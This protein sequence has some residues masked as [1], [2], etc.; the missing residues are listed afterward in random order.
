MRTRRTNG[1]AVGRVNTHTVIHRYRRTHFRVVGNDIFNQGIIIKAEQQGIANA[2]AGAIHA[3]RKEFTEDCRRFGIY[4]MVV[5]DY[6]RNKAQQFKTQT[7]MVKAFSH[8]RKNLRRQNRRRKG[9]DIQVFGL[10]IAKLQEMPAVITQVR[11]LVRNP[12]GNQFVQVAQRRHL[13]TK[14]FTEPGTQYKNPAVC[15]RCDIHTLNVYYFDRKCEIFYGALMPQC[16]FKAP[17]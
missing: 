5:T 14:G 16:F 3:V 4:R 7:G 6:A 17:T 11:K 1:T 9:F 2:L 12:K 10:V 8:A 15:T 13:R